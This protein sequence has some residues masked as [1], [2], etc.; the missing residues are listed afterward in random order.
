MGWQASSEPII[1][2]EQLA[3]LPLDQCDVQTVINADAMRA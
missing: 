1:G 3:T 2:G